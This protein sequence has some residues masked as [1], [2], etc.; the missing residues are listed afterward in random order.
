MFEG[1][2]HLVVVEDLYVVALDLFRRVSS[3]NADGLI[4][5]KPEE[6]VV[7]VYLESGPLARMQWL[8]P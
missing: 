5:D 2:R 7:V 3:V 8:R 4:V 6:P 1:N